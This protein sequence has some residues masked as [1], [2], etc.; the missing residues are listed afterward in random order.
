MSTADFRSNVMNSDTSSSA[1][2]VDTGV[3]TD[4]VESA[5][6][7]SAPEPEATPDYSWAQSLETYKEGLHGL[8]LDELLQSLAQ[9]QLPEALWDKIQLPLKDGELEWSGNVADLRNGAMMREKF[10]QRMQKFNADR[11][12]FE[13]ERTGFVDYLRGWQGDTTGEALLNGLES[14]GMPIEQM[15][16]RLATR[17]IQRDKMLELEQS[18]QLP[19]G[20]AEAFMQQHK[21]QREAEQARR[22]LARRQAAEQSQRAD[23]DGAALGNKIKSFAADQF[24][25]LGVANLTEGLWNMFVQEITP[26]WTAQGKPPSADQ[27]RYAVQQAINTAR[28]YQAQHA[29][30]VKAATPTIQTPRQADPGAPV[31]PKTNVATQPMTTEQFRKMA[32]IR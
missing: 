8:K 17:L 16:E 3:D 23:Q 7:E 26:I 6:E 31:K 32:G 22:E 13:A 25:S 9:G 21:L 20:T 29:A 14:L 5:S 4:A 12:A 19:P 30:A 10:T 24:K 27:V 18:G 1:S 11:Q 2:S 28:S 15:A